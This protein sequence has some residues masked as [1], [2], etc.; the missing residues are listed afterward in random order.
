MSEQVSPHFTLQEYHEHQRNQ[1]K[2]F[3]D[4]NVQDQDK[5]KKDSFLKTTNINKAIYYKEQMKAF[6]KNQ[7]RT[8]IDG[9]KFMGKKKST[10]SPLILSRKTNSLFGMSTPAS[11]KTST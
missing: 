2:Q 8:I 10:P 6:E 4:N 5:Q 7:L 11:T 9:Q 3:W 1:N